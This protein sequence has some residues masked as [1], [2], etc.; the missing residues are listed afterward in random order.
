MTPL[1]SK[2]YSATRSSSVV[3]RRAARGNNR[4]K[5]TSNQLF[6]CV[7]VDTRIGQQLYHVVGSCET[8]TVGFMHTKSFRHL[9]TVKFSISH[10][11]EPRWVVTTTLNHLT[12]WCREPPH[13]C[14]LCRGGNR[15]RKPPRTLASPRHS[16]VFVGSVFR[17]W[18]RR[19]SLHMYVRLK[20]PDALFRCSTTALLVKTTHMYASS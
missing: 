17:H 13:N 19:G 5:L 11:H 8:L 15:C 2:T 18:Y 6:S 7:T 9:R 3:S 4:V 20:I 12:L 16:H 1:N 14:I 10:H